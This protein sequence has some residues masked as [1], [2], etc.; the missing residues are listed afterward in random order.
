MR[1]VIDPAV[2]ARFPELRVGVVVAR[3]LDN[4]GDTPAVAAEWDALPRAVPADWAALPQI[5]AWRA[6]Y[7]GLGINLKKDPPTLEYNLKKLA[8]GKPVRR[9][10]RVVDLYRLVSYAAALQFGGYDLSRV[11]GDIRLRTSPGGEPFEAI[12]PDK[13]K[14][15]EPGEVVYADDT[16]VLTRRWNYND[17]AHAEITEDTTDLAL[18]VEAPAAA[19]TTP[20][21]EAAVTRLTDL[22]RTHCGGTARWFVADVAASNEWPLE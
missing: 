22:L 17:S 14:P 11:S 13:S 6:V 15:T 2:A 16:R 4:R 18:F 20:A 3:G 5:A 7:Q 12:T 8:A 10:S 9:V 19:V 21:V 1:L